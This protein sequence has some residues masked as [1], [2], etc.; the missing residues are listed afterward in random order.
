MCKHSDS[1]LLNAAK[2]RSRTVALLQHYYFAWFNF[3]WFWL[4]PVWPLWWLWCRVICS[5]HGSRI[6]SL[7]HGSKN[8]LPCLVLVSVEPDMA[9]DS[10]SFLINWM[11][12][13]TN[14]SCWKCIDTDKIELF[15]PRHETCR[16]CSCCCSRGHVSYSFIILPGWTSYT[17]LIFF[18][19]LQ[20]K[21]NSAVHTTDAISP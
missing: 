2:M 4:F 14:I 17:S 21:E 6:R 12:T 1:Q 7:V 5:E 8:L 16:T 3:Y 19:T 20:S 10:Y 15:G 9:I 13:Y 18:L 11:R